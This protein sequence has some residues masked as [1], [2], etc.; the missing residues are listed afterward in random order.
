MR[1]GGE[2]MRRDGKI[3]MVLICFQPDPK[4]TK[5]KQILKTELEIKPKEKSRD[6]K[7]ESKK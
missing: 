4:E 6:K 2:E 1:R 5:K 3:L 7:I